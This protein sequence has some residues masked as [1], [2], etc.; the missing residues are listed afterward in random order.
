MDRKRVFLI[1][2][3]ISSLLGCA[4]AGVIHDNLKIPAGEI[5]ENQFTGIR[6]PFRVSAPPPWKMSTDFPDFLKQFGY[7]KP[8]PLDKEVTELYIFNPSTQSNIQIDFTPA[9]PGVR[10][11]QEWIERTTSMAMESFKGEIEKEYG[12]GVKVEYT[13][14]TPSSLKGVSYAAKDYATYTANGV[15]YENGW[16]YGYEKPNQIF[17]LYMI[18]EKEGAAEGAKDRE[19][20]KKIL[21]SFE[22]FSK[23]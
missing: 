6:Y 22:V 12:S 7:E 15:K 13:P 9:N 10:P 11:S 2:M 17:I 16:I 14:T 4:G 3:L 20:L 1:I 23:P 21:D 8:G 5:S 18:I 19:D